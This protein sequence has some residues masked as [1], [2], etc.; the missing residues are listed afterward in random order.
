M[1][2]KVL[3]PT[4]FA[5]EN[6]IRATAKQTAPPPEPMRGL[7]LS[8]REEAMPVLSQPRFPALE[9]IAVEG[10][11]SNETWQYNRP[12]IGFEAPIDV[13]LLGTIIEKYGDGQSKSLLSWMS[14]L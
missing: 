13:P 3:R 9:Q 11:P 10:L 7:R 4:W 6:A 1:G 5:D 8:I 14:Y 12:R 2:L